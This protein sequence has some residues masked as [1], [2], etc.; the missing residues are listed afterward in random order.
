MARFTRQITTSIKSENN[1]NDT[2]IIILSAGVGNRIK[3]NEP[4]SLIKIGNKTLIEHQI[5]SIECSIENSEIIGVFG[6]AIEKIIKKIGQ[7][8]RIVEKQ[9]YQQ[10]HG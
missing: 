1:K 5:D 6:Y 7:Q 3:S 4:R 9:I 2:A 8:I 10:P